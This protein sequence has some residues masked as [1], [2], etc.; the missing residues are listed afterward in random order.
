MDLMRYFWDAAV[1]L[2]P[3][4]AS[5]DE[6]LRFPLCRPEA[7]EQLFTVAG[8]EKVEVAHI[9]IPTPFKSFD[10]YWQPFLGGQGPAPAYAM[11]LEEAGRARLRD[12]LRERI[13]TEADGSISLTARALATRATVGGA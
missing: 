11:S 2:D 9:D 5:Q 3:K 8:L 13:P 4:A 12:H 7:L 1:E 10:D 6:G